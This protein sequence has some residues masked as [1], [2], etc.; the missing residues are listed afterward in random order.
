MPPSPR[1]PREGGPPRGPGPWRDPRFVAAG[2]VALVSLAGILVGAWLWAGGSGTGGRG[3]V[4]S[5]FV[6]PV[7]A[8]AP[9]DRFGE[10]RLSVDGRCVRVLVA[11]TE[12]RRTRGLQ[13]VRDLGPYAG[14]LFVFPDDTQRRF[15]MANTPTPLDIG[16]YAADGAPVDRTTMAPCPDGTSAACPLYESRGPYRYALETPA[17]TGGGAIAPCA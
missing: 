14:M 9:F 17:G 12:D 15:T 5:G 6:T 1:S 13:D 8:A 3:D 2:A 4:A 16:W 11:D 10:A 7:P